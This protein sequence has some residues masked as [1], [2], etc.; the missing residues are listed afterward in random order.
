M[1]SGFEAAVWAG[2]SHTTG[3]ETISYDLSWF[4]PAEC[5]DIHVRYLLEW[6][7]GWGKEKVREV[8]RLCSVRRWGFP[9]KRNTCRITF[10]LLNGGLAYCLY[11][12]QPDTA[13]QR[14][15]ASSAS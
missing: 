6:C 15:N 3:S 13:Y 5:E 10:V 12:R 14:S 8:A 1:E 4:W 9:P 2:G 11:V 7:G